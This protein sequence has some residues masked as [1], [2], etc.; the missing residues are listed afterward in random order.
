MVCVSYF[1]IA[2]MASITTSCNSGSGRELK[3]CFTKNINFFYCGFMQNLLYQRNLNN[4]F[5]A[6]NM[7]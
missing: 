2:D 3:T 1:Q 7:N 6:L 5:S 4:F